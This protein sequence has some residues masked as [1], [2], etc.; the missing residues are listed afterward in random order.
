MDEMKCKGIIERVLTEKISALELDAAYQRYQ[1]EDREKRI[2]ELEEAL[3]RMAEERDTL[4]EDNARYARIMDGI[5]DYAGKLAGE[6]V[7]RNG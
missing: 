1:I 5:M 4:R 3:E 2:K 6:E 7:E